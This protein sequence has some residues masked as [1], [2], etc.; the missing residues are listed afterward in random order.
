MTFPGLLERLADILPVI[1]RNAAAN[2]ELGQL[3]EETPAALHRVG[4]AGAFLPE[5]GQ[6]FS[7][8]PTPR[9]SLARTHAQ[10]RRHRWQ[11]AT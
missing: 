10:V 3:N 6:R 4:A 11:M 8:P 5:A 2:E 7:T 1:L 9:S